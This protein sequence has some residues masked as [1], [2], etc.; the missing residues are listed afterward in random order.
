M[1]RL[2]RSLFLK[3][4]K[5]TFPELREEIN[6]QGGRLHL[7]MHVFRDFTQEQINQGHQGRVRKCFEIADKCL[8]RGNKA[9]VGAVRVSFLEHLEFH[10][11]STKR[12]WAWD[13]MPE[14]LQQGY[15]D[16]MAYI[17]EMYR[18]TVN[19]SPQPPP[20][21]REPAKRHHKEPKGIRPRGGSRRRGR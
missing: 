17:E 11:D 13:V 5:E 10:D 4:V 18:R 16:I 14:A 7:E 15:H 2:H 21:R 19:S 8:R 3:E 1:R 20:T 12:S 9:L 6:D